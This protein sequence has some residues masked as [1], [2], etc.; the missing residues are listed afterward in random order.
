MACGISAP[1]ATKKGSHRQFVLDTY[2]KL[3]G[4]LTVI[5]VNFKTYICY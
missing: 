4:I 2:R 3:E 1:T 5:T